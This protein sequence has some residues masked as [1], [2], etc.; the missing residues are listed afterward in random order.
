MVSNIYCF[1]PYLGKIPILIN[2]FQRVWN[3]QL[4]LEYI[5]LGGASL[6]V[7]M[8]F[9]HGWK[10]S[11]N[12]ILRGL[13][14]LT[15]VFFCLLV[16]GTIL[17][18]DSST[19]YDMRKSEVWRGYVGK[20]WLVLNPQPVAHLLITKHSPVIEFHRWLHTASPSLTFSLPSSYIISQKLQPH[21]ATFRMANTIAAV[22]QHYF[23]SWT[24]S[25]WT[26]RPYLCV[27]WEKLGTTIP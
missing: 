18:A 13:T 17:Q 14:W 7:A 22:C 27:N 26:T 24:C 2:I 23:L 25:G 4:G 9:G 20:I 1:R 16:T 12:P 8:K 5:P 15:M 3:H 21:H 11:H 19:V 10:G 6:L